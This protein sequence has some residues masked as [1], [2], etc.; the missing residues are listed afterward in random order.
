MS[1]S[2]QPTTK[3][4]HIMTIVHGESELTICKYIGS[5][6][7][8]KHKEIDERSGKSS[9]QI[10]GLMKH[11]NNLNFMDIKNFINEYDNI[12][13]V[14]DKLIEFKIFPIMDTDDCDEQTK[15][16]YKTGLMFKGHFLEPYIVPI[17]N[18]PNLEAT[19]ASI[20]IIIKDKKEYKKIFPVNSKGINLEKIK[21]FSDKLRKSPNT[22]MEVYVDYCIKIAESELINP[23]RNKLRR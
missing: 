21:F 6:L 17:Y 18:E 1:K 7:R 15:E 2:K 3:S 8:I 5:S 11:L 22:N 16:N 9:I 23:N 12:K 14:K 10:N 20:G 13:V 19:M 4:L